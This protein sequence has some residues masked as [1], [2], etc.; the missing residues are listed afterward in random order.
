MAWYALTPSPAFSFTVQFDFLLNGEAKAS[1]SAFL[2]QERELEEYKTVPN[3]HPNYCPW[4]CAV[5]CSALTLVATYTCI[6]GY[7][8]SVTYVVLCVALLSR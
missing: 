1:V 2:S 6:H 5:Q 3:N 7:T 8:M 4:C